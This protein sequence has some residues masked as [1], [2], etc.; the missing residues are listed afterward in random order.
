MNKISKKEYNK[1]LQLVIGVII[2]I[3]ILGYIA[4]RLDKKDVDDNKEKN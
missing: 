3:T 2:V 1:L 4:F